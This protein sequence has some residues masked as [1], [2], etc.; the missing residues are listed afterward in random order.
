MNDC[1]RTGRT[2]PPK[3]HQGLVSCFF[4]LVLLLGCVFSAL[5]ILNIR[6]T[7]QLVNTQDSHGPQVR[8][9]QSTAAP[10][11]GQGISARETDGLSRSYFGWPQGVYVWN[12]VRDSTAYRAGLRTGDILTRVGAAPVETL[13]ALEEALEGSPESLTV[14]RQGRELTLHL[15]E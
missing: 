7:W 8:F 3:S 5:R 12:V 10:R 11:A 1:Y 6:L 15:G 2:N 4:V 13:A 9:S 14:Y